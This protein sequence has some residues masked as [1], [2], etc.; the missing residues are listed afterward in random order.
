MK[1]LATGLLALTM[2]AILPMV[3]VQ[4]QETSL[5][6]AIDTLQYRLTVEWDQKDVG[7]QKKIMSDFTAELDSLKK[8]GVTDQE[9]FK[10]LSS[11]AFDAQTSK[12]IEN[13][14]QYAQ[15]NKLDQKQVR[16]LVVDYANKSQK[17]GTSWSSEATVGVIVG[18][19]LVIVLVA[20]L[21]GNL[22]VQT[23][24]GGYYN[25]NCYD[26]CY[27]DAYGYYYCDTYCY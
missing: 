18:I 5:N 27:Y 15:A 25:S 2:A 20:A 26:N 11:K 13:L 24:T 19:A 8:Q 16:K 10:S 3:Q 4:A 6:S 22:T 9:I 7:A 21:T 1:K 23:T 14:A 12:D 17:L